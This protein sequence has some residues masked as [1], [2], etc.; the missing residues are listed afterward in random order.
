MK[1]LFFS[2]AI[3][4]PVFSLL[5]Y[6]PTTAQGQKKEN[7]SDK[8]DTAKLGIVYDKRYQDYIF[9]RGSYESPQRLY[10]IIQSLK[11]SILT[12]Q[13]TWLT[14][15][16]K[17]EQYLPLAHTQ[18]HISKI[19]SDERTGKAAL[20]AVSGALCG[21][22]AVMTSKVSSVFCAVRPPGHH[23]RNRGKEEGFCYFNNAALAARY[24]QNKYG[25][26][27]VLI[28][29]WDYHH[30]NGTEEIFYEDSTVLFFSTHNANDF[31]GTGSPK[32][33]GKGA[34]KGLS[35]NVHLRCRTQDNDI[36]SA[37]KQKLVPAAEAFMPDLVVISAGFDSR[38]DDPLGCFDIT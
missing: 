10:A 4:V 3:L 35:I 36:I 13:I 26:K 24:A 12:D 2:N 38:K 15:D 21:I 14:P 11:N 37:F 1:S 20:L 28:V 7:S 16:K 29:D 19:L 5:L 25:I 9:R 30:G 23:A 22:D 34:G 18:K 17:A 6:F 8:S 32:R 27:K 31:P 33:R